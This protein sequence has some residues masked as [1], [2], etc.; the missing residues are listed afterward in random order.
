MFTETLELILH[1][2]KVDDKLIC[3]FSAVQNVFFP[4]VVK[5]VFQIRNWPSIQRNH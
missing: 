1:Y 3:F 5:N 2:I 4:G